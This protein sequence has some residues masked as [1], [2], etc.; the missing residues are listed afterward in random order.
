VVGCIISIADTLFILM[1]YRAD[2]TLRRLRVFEMFVSVFIIGVFVS[3]CIE[4]SLV[5]APAAE[6]MRGFLPSREIFVS[7]G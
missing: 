1:F 7:N 4:L 2:G 6:I 3:F 5:A